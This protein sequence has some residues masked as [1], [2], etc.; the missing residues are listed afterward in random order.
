MKLENELNVLVMYP[1]QQKQI[2][3]M[4]EIDFIFQFENFCI[5]GTKT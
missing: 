1:K 3:Q 5:L 4:Y 2:H